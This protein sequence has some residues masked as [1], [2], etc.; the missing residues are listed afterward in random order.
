MKRLLQGVGEL[1][2]LVKSVPESAAVQP[3]SVSALPQLPEP[4]L[5][6]PDDW[7]S[8]KVDVGMN[9]SVNQSEVGV[10]S[11]LPPPPIPTRSSEYTSSDLPPPQLPPKRKTHSR[12]EI[13][14]GGM[15]MPIIL[16]NYT[17]I[18]TM[19]V[20]QIQEMMNIMIMEQGSHLVWRI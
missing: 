13:V 2:E 10:V 14:H 6:P 11:S 16:Y 9:M 20:L 7:G 18:Q 17:A 15:Y 12:K 4:I 19:V 5:P 3:P 1:T 8:D